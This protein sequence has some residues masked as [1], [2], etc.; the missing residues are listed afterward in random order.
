ML[1]YPKQEINNMT[2]W[3]RYLFL[4]VFVVSLLGLGAVTF[5]QDATEESNTS[6]DSSVVDQVK[7]D[8]SAA[9]YQS[10][11]QE[12]ISK[13]KEALKSS[14]TKTQQTRVKARCKL[15]QVKVKVVN[16]KVKTFKTNRVGV[17][18][19]IAKKLTDL[20]TKLKNGGVETSELDTQITQL[21]TL[22]TNFQTDV[23]ELHQHTADLANMNCQTDP[24]GFKAALEA[25]RT[26]RE[27][28]ANDSKAI[29]SYITDTIKPTLSTLK[30]S[31]QSSTKSEGN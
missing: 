13:N 23:S 22:I 4:A 9:D 27:S 8:P 30:T 7:D 6:A 2:K 19:K 12:R 29:R 20:S 18:E 26:E 24:S 11:L 10:K 21:Q 15:A 31:V 3:A 1:K 5:A 25:L 17:Y 28:V 16:D 14:L